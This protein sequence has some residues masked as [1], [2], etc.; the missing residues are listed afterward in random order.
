MV[1]RKRYIPLIKK[2]IDSG[3]N[4]AAKTFDGSPVVIY[5]AKFGNVKVV[6]CIVESGADVNSPKNNGITAL[7]YAA[8]DGQTDIVRELLSAGANANA[9]TSKEGMTALHLASCAGHS[10]TVRELL[11]KDISN[12]IILNSYAAALMNGHAAIVKMLINEPVNN[13]V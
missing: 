4:I 1:I 11:E 6:R 8:A 13:S 3:A 12:D 9:R 2:L 10:Y 7:H 5:A